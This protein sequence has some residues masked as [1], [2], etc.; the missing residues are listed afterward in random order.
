[1]N[2][3]ILDEAQQDLKEGAEFYD[4]QSKG[5]GIYFID[6]LLA[7]IESL[8]H[9]AGV[10]INFN[11]YFRLLSKTFPY[12]I[13]YRING[14]YIDVYAVLDCRKNPNKTQDKLKQRNI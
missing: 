8:S 5:L 14:D 4:K 12:A 6:I 1:M 13:Y 10:H 11:S 3:R 7:D 2:I 9:L